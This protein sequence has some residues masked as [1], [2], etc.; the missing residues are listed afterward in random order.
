MCSPQLSRWKLSRK[1][2]KG[3]HSDEHVCTF[4]RA[5]C[6]HE[7]TLAGLLHG[8]H[9][10][11]RRRCLC[12]EVDQLG[13]DNHR[14]SGSAEFHIL[15]AT[16]ERALKHMH[17]FLHV[18]VLSTDIPSGVFFGRPNGTMPCSDVCVQAVQSSQSV[19]IFSHHSEHL[20]V[21]FCAHVH[22]LLSAASRRGEMLWPDINRRC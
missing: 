9:D 10:R 20:E 7:R 21:C 11:A 22:V 6:I 5:W 8:A 4:W 13:L 17:N 15:F 14:V 2:V 18:R 1:Q 16:P 19:S 3:R 12:R